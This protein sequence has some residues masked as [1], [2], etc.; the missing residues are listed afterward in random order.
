M[1]R[2]RLILALV[3]LLLV[4]LPLSVV[5]YVALTAKGLQFV[6]SHI[7]KRIGRA[8]I[9]IAPPRGTLVGGFEVA[10]VEIDHERSHLVFQGIQG[11]LSVLSL[12]WQTVDARDVTVKSAFVEV[13]RRKRPSNNKNPRF[14]PPGLVIRIAGARVTDGTLIATNGRRFDITGGYVSGTIRQHTIRLFDTAFDWQAM[15]V[16][17]NTK[18]TAGDPMKIAGNARI[19]LTWP[20]QPVWTIDATAKGDLDLLPL[21]ASIT[22]PFRADFQGRAQDLTG[23]WNWSGEA[24]VHDFDLQAWGAGDALGRIT[25]TLTLRGDSQG[26]GARGPLTPAG[27]KAGAFQTLFEG[28]YA[29]RVVTADRIEIQHP[30]GAVVHGAGSITVVDK[31]PRLDLRGT[32]QSFRWPLVGPDVAVRSAS[33]DY[34]LS[35]VWPYEWRAAGPMVARDLEPMPTIGRGRLAKDRAYL[36][37]VSF[38]G[39]G[40][41][42]VLSGEVAWSP[43]ETWR[44]TGHTTGL[45]PTVFRKDLPGKIN[46]DFDA[47]G[48]GF[49]G[50]GD[51]SFA[52]RSLSGRLRG[53]TASGGGTVARRGKAWELGGIRIGLG[54]TQIEASGRIGS[55]VDL[56]FALEAEDLSWLHEQASGRLSARGRVSGTADDPVVLASIHGSSLHHA[57][58]NL[59]RLDAD[60]DFDSRSA[61]PAN[62]TLKA[63]ELVYGKRT[64][65]SIDFTLQGPAA[66]HVAQL[67]A[68]APNLSLELHATGAF[69]HGVWNGQLSRLDLAGNE[70]LNLALDSPV[71]LLI[72]SSQMRAERLCLH[73]SPGR[74][75]ADGDWTPEKWAATL[76]AS[77]L[78]LRTFTAGLTP[79]VDYRGSLTITARA[80]GARGALPEGS[81]RADLVDTRMVHRLSSGKLQSI[82]LGSGLVTLEAT[83]G[84]IDAHMGLDAGPIGTIDGQ[85][86]LARGAHRWQ[87]MPLRGELKVRT[88]ELGF[89]TLYAPQI[90]RAA[91]RLETD[92][93]L[94][95]TAGTPLID[96]T[97]RLADAELDQ[98]QVNLALR[99]AN[100]NARLQGNGLEF[101]GTAR[102]GEGRMRT[103]GKL[104]WRE[105]MPYG[106]LHLEGERLR[107]ADVPE[108]RID[109]SPNLDFEIEGRR[110]TAS[111]KVEVP[112][113]KIQPTDLRNAVRSSADEIIVGEKA[114]D[115]TKR[116]QV[117]T[118]IELKLADRVS[119]DTSGLT[120]RL[121]GN[122][123]VRSGQDEMTRGQG[124]L[125]VEEGKYVAYGRKLDI[126]RGRLI[127][128]GGPVGNPGVDIRA[129][130][131]FP[132]VVAGVNVR[133]TLLQPRLTFFSE[134]SLPQS[135]IFSLILAGGSLSSATQGPTRQTGGGGELLAQGGAIL[136]SQFGERVGIEDVSVES[137]MSNETSLVLGKYL[138]PRLYVS[139]GIS[140]AESIN[141]LKM[142]YSLNDHW[143]IRSEVGEARGAD[144]VFTIEK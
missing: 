108:A 71:G 15:H 92:L 43:A 82:L 116:F 127:F 129:V 97:I 107:V 133:G 114:Q 126:Q 142:R 86:A 38:D 34:Q 68:K 99:E 101:D 10:R 110:I 128:T 61:K 48:A 96:G 6:A 120:G 35:G 9:E 132:E 24:Q 37:E 1:T 11:R 136:A 22:A 105:A 50:E 138:S 36:D 144:L 123:R 52:M 143:T 94:S 69:A 16:S 130:K 4:A 57:G 81:L 3:L 100:L 26:F 45:D 106:K 111:G 14:L 89:V 103:H 30:S 131:Q 104:E 29:D 109:A 91:G 90:D 13:R 102:V 124:E 141:T 56:G 40:G 125:L 59:A 60:I 74:V 31:G 21:Q 80:S 55:E 112:Y 33:G 76:N 88:A 58:I 113:A 42:T 63:R 64:V 118:D 84:A 83:P 28:S 41:H 62:V 121:V 137:N 18:L 93:A 27:L 115:P 32:W 85:M 95:G 67:A 139:Y 135:Q 2:G 20:D 78:P 46:F 25:G 122:L 7:P 39:F 72:S 75:C 119:I 87:D 134:P 66:N 79:D 54:R 73:G 53:V 8:T 51:F 23:Q 70:S 19:T 98:Y 5:A 47:Q 12:L 65:D 117:V 17:G 140:L 77:D 49:D 44:V